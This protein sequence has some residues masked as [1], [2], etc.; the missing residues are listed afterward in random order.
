MPHIHTAPGQH[1]FTASA[2]I[3]RELDGGWKCLVH[4]HKKLH[5]LMQ[6]GGHIELDE[7]PWQS[8]RHELLEEA[9]YKIETLSVLQ[10]NNDSFGSKASIA[11]PV[12]VGL[13]THCFSQDH[14]HTDLA[15]AFVAEAG[16][17]EKLADGESDDLRWV[18]IGELQQ[19]AESGEALSDIAEIYTKIVSEYLPTYIRKPATDFSFDH[20]V[21]A[22]KDKVSHD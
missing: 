14:Y 20:P 12:P 2:Y 10:P 19:F 7:T 15:Y 3:V 16:P 17:S 8:L 22:D 9:G 18:G 1:D 4:Y 5:K 13:N 21:M 6:V 11:H